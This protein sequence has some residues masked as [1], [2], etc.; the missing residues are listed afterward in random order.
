MEYIR[1]ENKNYNLHII[2]TERFKTITVKVN[3]KRPLIKEE[4]TKRN[5]LVNA[6][7]EGT[8]NY[9]SKRL[10]EIKTE[11]LY[12][13]G[14]RGVNYASGKFTMLSFEMTFINPRYTEA[15]MDEESFQFLE[16]FI[17]HPRVED[18]EIAHKNFD[19]AYNIMSDYLKTIKENTSA[20]S[21]MRMLEEMDDSLISYRG[22]GYIE[23]LEKISAKE[24]YEYYLDII[25]NDIVDIFIIGN[26]EEERAI[27]LVSKYLPFETNKKGHESHF[28]NHENVT[29]EIKF[30]KEKVD[31][32]QSTLVLGF[33]MEELTD[34][35]KRYVLSVYNYILGGS[36]ESNLFQTIREKYSL[37]YYITSKSL[38]LLNVSM[39]KSGINA[40]QYEETLSL[41]N[42]ELT[43][44]K[45]GQFDESKMDNAKITYINGLTELEDS[46]DNI[47]SLYAGMEYLDADSIEERKNNIMKVT[48]DDI[49]KLASKIHLNTIYLLEGSDDNEKE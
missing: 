33:K 3:L 31:K 5:L 39:I 14:Y 28:Y 42:D 6:L 35:E 27:Y 37:C 49:T 10:L 12:D 15:G 20:Y 2:K 1:K 40:Y 32:E 13:L 4:I 43:K 38:P 46:P 30:V 24:L 47:I 29:D 16:E 22:T 48:K 9:P 36:T 19:I 26:I 21:Q 41:I 45:Q 18:G 8:S 25:N 23:D 7:L 44:M 34:F 11:E 17:F